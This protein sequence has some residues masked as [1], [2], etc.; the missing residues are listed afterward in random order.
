VRVTT[1]PS[2]MGVQGSTSRVAR[3]ERSPLEQFRSQSPVVVGGFDFKASCAQAI[4]SAKI[5]KRKIRISVRSD[6]GLQSG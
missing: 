1:N 6:M 3:N 4:F 2:R 5:A